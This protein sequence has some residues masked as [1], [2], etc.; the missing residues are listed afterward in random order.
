MK[1]RITDET[2]GRTAVLA[3]C[4][5]LLFL[6]FPDFFEC[7]TA[8]VIEPY[9][10]GLKAYTNIAYHAKHDSSYT[11]F[12]GMNYPY[13]EH[14]AAAVTQPLIS[15]T[16]KFISAH[17]V[18]ISRYTPV[19][20][21]FS[22]LLG[23]LLGAFF[24]Y[25]CFR[26]LE[27]SIWWAVL[28]SI[29]MAFL[30]PQLNRFV[31]HYGLAH[32]EV[33]PV[34]FY[35]LMRLEREQRIGLSLWIAVA[36]SVFSLIHFYYFAIL[37]MTVSLY[38]FVGFLR[39]PSVQRLLRY[40]L[41]FSL[42]IVLPLLFFYWWMYAGDTI[43]DRSEMPWGFFY[44]HSIWENVVTSDAL[45]YFQ[46]ID[47][48]IISIQ[49][50]AEEGEAYL[51]LVAAAG[52][53]VLLGRWIGAGF[54]KPFVQVGGSLQ[55]FLNKMML[56]G[57]ILLLLSFGY[58]F[59]IP[60][61]EWMLE[62]TGPFKQFRSVGRFNWPFYYMLNLVVFAELWHWAKGRS[63]RM[64]LAV[65]A[66]LL[67]GY[68]S[69]TYATHKDLR[70][71]EIKWFK[72]GHRFT[73]IE[74]IAYDDFQAVVSAPH[75]N[76]GSDQFWYL[77]PGNT[78]PHTLILGVQAGLPTTSA[79]LTRTSRSQTLKQIQLISEPYRVPAA[80][81]DYPNDKPLLLLVSKRQFE[82]ERERYEHLLENVSLL[83]ENEDYALY[84]MPLHS[85]QERIDSRVRSLEHRLRTDSL[86]LYE[87]GEFLSQDS[88]YNFFY[89]SLDSLA[90]EQVY[91]GSGAYQGDAGEKNVIFDQRIPRQYGEGWYTFS[92][93]MYVDQDRIVRGTASIEEYEPQS[94]EVLKSQAYQL[95]QHFEVF[96]TNGWALLELPYIPA[97]SHSRIRWSIQH[98]KLKGVPLFLDEIL[99]RHQIAQLLRP[100]DDFLF[101]N[102]RWYQR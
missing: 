14:V 12:E 4:L 89:Q 83:Y 48:A 55:P 76:I 23:L 27:V 30:S 64:G 20:L 38:F 9:A 80:F 70:L 34:L 51:G 78:M 90:S 82:R 79:A 2:L 46:W 13:G 96:D 6:R 94:G 84:R 8:K 87:L 54:R 73:D 69:F 67:L 68:E 85:F 102:N 19:I 28:V 72:P 95:H 36:V 100:G 97:S 65:A 93:W 1:Q 40:A 58:P 66:L 24:L 3:L 86:Q 45:P 99:I 29:G 42:Q 81:S 63:W 75:F 57:F 91:Q 59:T 50:G 39:K 47:E 15:S 44:F 17:I 25:L 53:V 32:I 7:S 101:K 43:D 10:D 22:L 41:H 92:V 16:V 35:L 77:N 11:Y 98:E 31:S 61:L 71:D 49:E 52:F 18:D 56:A 21:N 60:G 88:T 74:G 33:F 5:L 26:Q 37:A 62:Y